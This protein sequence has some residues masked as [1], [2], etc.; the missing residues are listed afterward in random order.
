MERYSCH[1]IRYDTTQSAVCYTR[2]KRWLSREVAGGRR[3]IRMS[4]SEERKTT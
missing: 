1:V 2:N 4:M 3:G